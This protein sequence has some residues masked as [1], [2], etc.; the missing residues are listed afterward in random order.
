MLSYLV[1]DKNTKE[2]NALESKMFSRFV[3]NAQKKVEGN[4]FDNRK[5]VLEYDEVLRKQRE[6]IYGQRADVLF[7]DDISEQIHKMMANTCVRISENAILPDSRKGLID[8]KKLV[9]N[10]NG[11]Y[12]L[13]DTFTEDL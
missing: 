13:T 7:M 3:E 11:I 5:S 2:E 10:V 9:K 4:N 1:V 12:F 8:A 6:I